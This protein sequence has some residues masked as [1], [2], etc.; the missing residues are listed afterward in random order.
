MPDVGAS[1]GEM[2]H[3]LTTKHRWLK[4]HPCQH[5]HPSIAHPRL[6]N[7]LLIFWL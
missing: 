2:K 5:F 1:T 4:K 7:R 3:F 6:E